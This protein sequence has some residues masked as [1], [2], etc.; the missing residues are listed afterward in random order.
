MVQKMVVHYD[1]D[2]SDLAALLHTVFDL[3]Q[4]S[5]LVGVLSGETVIPLSALSD[6]PPLYKGKRLDLVIREPIARKGSSTLLQY[7]SRQILKILFLASIKQETEPDQ[8]PHHGRV[9]SA[10]IWRRQR[11][12]RRRQQLLRLP[13]RADRPRPLPVHAAAIC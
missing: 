5:V 2:P 8:R 12:K 10:L 6:N 7:G 4:G 1:A 11:V 3:Q 13:Q 9:A